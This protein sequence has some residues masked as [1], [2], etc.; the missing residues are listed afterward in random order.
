MPADAFGTIKVE[1][2]AIIESVAEEVLNEEKPVAVV[3]KN[4]RIVG[5]LRSKN[6][7]SYL[8]WQK[9]IPRHRIRVVSFLQ[10]F[11][12]GAP[13]AT[14]FIVLLAVF[15]LLIFGISP[16]EGNI[17]WRLPP[18]LAGL[19]GTVNNAMEY[20]LNDW[21]PIDIYDPEIEE[22]EESPLVKE[23]ARVF[24]RRVVLHSTY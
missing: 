18:L 1:K 8:V 2:E 12:K 6:D 19:P 3:D 22:Y 11:Y 16:S 23:I 21:F 13:K 17:L 24:R 7:Y 9:K 10:R 5:V 14:Q 20:M 4:R 15:F